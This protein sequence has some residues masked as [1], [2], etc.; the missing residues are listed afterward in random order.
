MEQPV[1]MF[2]SNSMDSPPGRGIGESN[3]ANKVFAELAA[4]PNWRRVLSN[5][6]PSDFVLDDLN[7]HSVEHYFHAQKFKDS[8]PD[9]YLEFAIDSGSVLSKSEGATVKHAG[10]KIKM[11]RVECAAWD[12]ISQDVLKRA[13]YAKFTQNEFCKRV[14]IATR[15]AILTHKA[16]RFSPLV[17]EFDLMTLRD[18][19]V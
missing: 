17:V 8:H 15:G 6:Y 11:S 12:R 2:N 18:E 14:L 3:P 4:I 10:R 1:F 9:Y 13:Q 7:W 16:S 19:L 5:F